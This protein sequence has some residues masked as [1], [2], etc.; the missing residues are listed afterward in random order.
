MDH[1]GMITPRLPV[2]TFKLDLRTRSLFREMARDIVAKDRDAR[3]H[4]HSQNTIGEIERALVKAHALGRTSQTNDVL[5]SGDNSK[6]IVDWITIPPRA[7]E[8]LMSMTTCFSERWEISPSQPYEIERFTE[9]G[10]IRW[11]IV[12]YGGRQDHSVANGSAA[13][14]A[15]MN[16]IAAVDEF[17]TRYALTAIGIATCRDYWRRSDAADPT[18]PRESMR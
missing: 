17:E 5:P 13:P 6:A 12:G 8:T 16:L 14:L 2:K 4:G 15:R 10:R 18:L 3:R 1:P 9:N 11:A 7:R